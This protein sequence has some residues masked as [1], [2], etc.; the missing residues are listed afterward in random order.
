MEDEISEIR[1]LKELVR[2]MDN[3]LDTEVS[4]QYREQPLA[5]N[6]ARVAKV[7]EEAGEAIDALI[8]VTGQNPRKGTYGSYDDLLNELA[9]VALTGMYALQHFTKDE[10]LMFAV[11]LNR[12]RFHRERR[13]LDH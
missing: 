7:V 3:D 4:P 5:Q 6:W 9:D 1:E 11:L 13:G 2:W 8:G 12:A 10:G